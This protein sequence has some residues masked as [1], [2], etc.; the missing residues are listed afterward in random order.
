M[1]IP[2]L[3]AYAIVNDSYLGV[4]LF[5]GP[6]IGYGLS[7]TIEETGGASESFNWDEAG[8]KRSDFSLVFGAATYFTV[9][10]SSK[11]AG[12]LAL[13][14]RYLHGLSN[15]AD[16]TNNPTEIKNRG[17][18]ISLGYAIPLKGK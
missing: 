18:A 10:F 6:S 16:E 14:V 15:I 3:A 5:A 17:L 8:I 13:D 9:A 7:G 1:E 11:F 12:I 2:V 4:D